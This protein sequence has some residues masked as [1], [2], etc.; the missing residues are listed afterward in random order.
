MVHG[1]YHYHTPNIIWHMVKNISMC[2]MTDGAW[3]MPIPYAK[4]DLACGQ[5]YFHMLNNIWRMEFNNSMR[6]MTDGAWRMSF[7]YES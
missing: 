4:Y 7:A 2:Q 3:R 6:Q 5:E 1:G